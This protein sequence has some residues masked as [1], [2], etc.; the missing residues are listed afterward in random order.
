MSK[1][2]CLI[3]CSEVFYCKKIFFYLNDG[4]NTSCPLES[5]FAENLFSHFPDE[6]SE[7]L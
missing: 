6:I 4:L 7:F 5:K 2:E 1:F 3:F